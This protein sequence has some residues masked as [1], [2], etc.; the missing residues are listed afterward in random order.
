MAKTK[1]KVPI[2]E[3][4]LVAR[5]NRKLAADG[6]KLKKARGANTESSV[7][8]FFIVNVQGNYVAHQRVD[9]VD[10]AQKL[11]VMEEWEMLAE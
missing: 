6:Q 9:I 10:L 7:G 2:A 3:R 11:K 5:I 1:T 4:A 8:L